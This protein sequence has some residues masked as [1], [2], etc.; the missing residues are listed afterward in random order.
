MATNTATKASP[1][2][3]ADTLRVDGA[4]GGRPSDGAGTGAVVST[5]AS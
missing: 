2:A 1:G 5:I 4:T 3:S